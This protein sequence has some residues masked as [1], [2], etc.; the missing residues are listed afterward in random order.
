MT[1]SFLN[2]MT[3]NNVMIV[4]IPPNCTDSWVEPLD[5]SVNKP[6][7]D[8]LK[9]KF[10]SWSADSISQQLKNSKAIKPVGLQVDIDYEAIECQVDN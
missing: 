8:F 4:E 9:R 3:A 5:L 2:Y 7:E 6:V 10:Q 1:E